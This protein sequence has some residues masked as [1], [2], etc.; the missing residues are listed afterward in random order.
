MDNYNLFVISFITYYTIPADSKF[1]FILPCC[2]IED[3]VPVQTIN[4]TKIVTLKKLA[5]SIYLINFFSIE[6]IKTVIHEA[7][8][9][10]RAIWVKNII[11]YFFKIT[12][13]PKC[14]R[15]VTAHSCLL[16]IQHLQIFFFTYWQ[17]REIRIEKH[18][19][20]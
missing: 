7:K 10:N 9:T 13:S 16:L 18:Y 11:I 12:T 6:V 2:G 20:T 3:I 14:T 5:L 8:L 17:Q 1:V 4:K 15:S 19:C